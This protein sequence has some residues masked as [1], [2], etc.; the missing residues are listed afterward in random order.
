MF[1]VT[2][3]LKKLK[4]LKKRIRGI[5]G[6]TSASKTISIL[7][8]LID[9]CQRDTTPQI[10]SVTSES[11]PHLKRGA[12]RDFKNIMLEHGYWKDDRWNATDF[13]YTFETGTPLEFF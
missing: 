3:A 10:T 7:Q 9:Q 12:M 2:T 11:M 4:Q 1:R 13:I 6:G 8:I 5:A